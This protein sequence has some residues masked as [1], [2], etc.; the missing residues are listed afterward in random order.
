MKTYTGT[1]TACVTVILFMNGIHFRAGGGLRVY[2]DVL[3][4]DVAHSCAI[5][6]SDRLI[7]QW[8][9]GVIH[10]QVNGLVSSLQGP[11]QRE[12]R[13]A[14]AFMPTSQVNIS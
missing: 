8:C 1:Y 11:G 13:I 9:G 2:L 5:E 4:T 10:W 3:E 6:F 12:K 14:L 7:L